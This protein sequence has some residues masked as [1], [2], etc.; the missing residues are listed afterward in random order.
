[1]GCIYKKYTQHTHNIHTYTRAATHK[2][3][4]HEKLLKGSQSR[5][6]LVSAKISPLFSL[7]C[8]RKTTR[9]KKRLQKNFM[10]INFPDHFGSWKG[11][12]RKRKEKANEWKR[13]DCET[14]YVHR[15]MCVGCDLTLTNLLHIHSHS[16]FQLH[17]SFGCTN[18]ASLCSEFSLTHAQDM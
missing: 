13:H 2:R 8:E 9:Q 6:G 12:R 15:V 1:M 11:D 7:S 17:V 16:I 4:L 3:Q 14:S 10:L 5:T 18:K